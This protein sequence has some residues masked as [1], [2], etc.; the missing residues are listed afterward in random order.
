MACDVNQDVHTDIYYYLVNN[1]TRF[2]CT[3]ELMGV[4]YLNP[5]V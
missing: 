4:A 1:G 3:Y 5:R 2:E